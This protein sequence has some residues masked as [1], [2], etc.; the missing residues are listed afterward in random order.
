[1]KNEQLNE[2]LY[3]ALETELGGVQIYETAIGCAI[4][5]DLKAEW[6]EY[7]EQTQNHVKIVQGVFEKLHLDPQTD[8]RRRQVVRHIGQSLRKAMEMA[9]SAGKPEAAQLVAVECVV[10]AGRKTI[11]TGSYWRSSQKRWR[12]SN[13]L[14]VGQ[15]DI[16]SRGSGQES[17][18]TG[19]SS[20]SA[21]PSSLTGHVVASGRQPPPMVSG[22]AL[23]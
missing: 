14:H 9:L 1:V 11:S 16:A 3:E 10:E 21:A 6:K 5:E 23:V 7:L 20:P 4:N 13:Q 8:T 17:A 22:R 2:L 15:G 18:Q 19:P 12:R